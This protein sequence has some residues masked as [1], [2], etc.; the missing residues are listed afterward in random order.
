VFKVD[1]AAVYQAAEAFE[2]SANHLASAAEYHQAPSKLEFFDKG[3]IRKI[4]G[5]HQEFARL[6]QVRLAGAAAA[7]KVSAEELAKMATFYRQAN[8]AVAAKVDASVPAVERADHSA[9]RGR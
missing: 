5:S 1:P 2:A 4:E 7:L 8:M 3:I 9:W 6:L